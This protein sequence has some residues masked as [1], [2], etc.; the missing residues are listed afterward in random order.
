MNTIISEQVWGYHMN[1]STY[2]LSCPPYPQWAKKFDQQ[3]W[4]KLG[5]VVWDAETQQI[6]HLFGGQALRILEESWDADGQE[7]E[8]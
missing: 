4:N 7:I 6:T 8:R 1:D 5:V 3:H 2:T